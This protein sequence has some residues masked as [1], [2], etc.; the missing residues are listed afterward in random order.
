MTFG[1]LTRAEKR[2]EDPAA[3]V[4]RC[5]FRGESRCCGH[6]RGP[7]LAK[8]ARTKLQLV[9]ARAY[10]G[11]EPRH[12]VPGFAAVARGAPGSRSRI[13]LAT[14]DVCQFGKVTDC[15]IKAYSGDKRG[16]SSRFLKCLSSIR[17]L[18]LSRLLMLSTRVPY[19]YSA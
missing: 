19:T 16:W 7:S 11:E 2:N 9:G 14:F 8:C 17:G 4:L 5:G 18:P 12:C 3:R 6:L 10:G 13:R 1:P 15:S